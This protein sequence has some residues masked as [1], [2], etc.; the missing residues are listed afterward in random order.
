MKIAIITGGD[1]GEREVSIK[2]AENIRA[3]I[4]F[5]EIE[6]FVFPEQ[7]LEF[8]TDVKKFN[9]VIPM[10]HGE[11]GEDGALQGFLELLG[12]PYLFSG[13]SAHAIAIDKKFT[14]EVVAAIGIISPPETNQFPAF[15]KPR[16]GG[17]S[18]MSKFFS[19]KS[20]AKLMIQENPDIEFM[21]ESPIHGREFTVGVIECAG[22]ITLLPVIEIVTQSEFFDY[23]SKYNLAKLANEIC[24]ANI[25]KKLTDELQRQALL[26][27]T[28]LGARHMSRSDFILDENN[29]IYFL[30]INTIPGMTN[31]S[32]IPKAVSVLGL[33]MREVLK[34]W[35][36]DCIR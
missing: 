12:V 27:H 9:L 28:H 13:V 11:G 33:S 29:H 31:T 2:S 22:M 14:K 17:S 21:V 35:C 16:R 19:E 4:D 8:I 6:T 5:G 20:D 1:T 10:I 34:D 32:L 30:E 3:L 24:P 7:K 18:V 25:D 15:V 36:N 23:E 26:V